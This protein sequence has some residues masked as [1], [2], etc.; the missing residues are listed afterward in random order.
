MVMEMVV[1][2]V[3]GNP[4][5]GGFVQ[6]FLYYRIFVRVFGY[7]IF[8]VRSSY[9][10]FYIL[11]SVQGDNGQYRRV[12]MGSLRATRPATLTVVVAEAVV[13]AKA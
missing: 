13:V 8:L 4:F 9:V 10:G 2:M 1:G 7:R 12:A 6:Y 11:W 5:F 3:V